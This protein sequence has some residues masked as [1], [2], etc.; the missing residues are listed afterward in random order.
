MKQWVFSLLVLFAIVSG[1]FSQPYRS[2]KE[3]QQALFDSLWNADR[4]FFLAGRLDT[5]PNLNARLLQLAEKIREDSTFMWAYNAVGNYF[6]SK[7]NYS[8]A[9]EYDFRAAHI[10]EERLPAYAA[11]LDAN[12]A[13]VYDFLGNYNMALYY[14]LKGQQLLPADKIS[15]KVYLP[16]VFATVYNDMNKPDSALKYI[17]Q[18]YQ[19]SLNVGK[20]DIRSNNNMNRGMIY[21]NFGRV[22]T[23]LGEPELVSHYYKKGIQF[24]DSVKLPRVSAQLLNDYCGYLAKDRKYSEAKNYGIKGFMMGSKSGYKRFAADAADQLFNVYRQQHK[25]DSAYYYLQAKNVYQDS[26]LAEQ[27]TNQLQA[28]I[29]A[30]QIKETEQKAKVAQADEQRHRNIQYAAIALGL[31]LFVM[32]FLLLSRSIIVNTRTIEIVGVIGLLIVFEFINL[33][34]HP[35]LAA[36]TNESPIL[37][38]LILVLIASLIAP[39]HHKLEGWIKHRLVE[40]NKTIRLAAAKRTVE[41]LGGK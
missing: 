20:P 7:A 8:L 31:V 34:L 32:L 15:G 26:I 19:Q 3:K 17:Q 28:I 38:L 41:K 23:Q 1:F 14:L 6:A 33:V 18:A 25:D 9:L 29:I 11:V 13:G 5:L 12:L 27:K 35:Y 24:C 36:F 30:Q 22:Y 37:M 16:I 21:R 2:I 40:K 4:A 10:A 39:M